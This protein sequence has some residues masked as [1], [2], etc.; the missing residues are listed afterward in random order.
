M[1]K[2]RL[3]P[4][5]LRALVPAKFF[6][7][8]AL[9]AGIG[10][11][12]C[13]KE[14]NVGLALQ[15]QT[16]LLNSRVTDTTTLSTWVTKEKPLP[17]S[18]GLYQFVLGHYW[19]PIFGKTKASI[20]TQFVLP[21]SIINTDFAQG[22]DE[23]KLV[24]DSLVVTLGYGKTFYGD[25][26][27]LQTVKVYQLANPITSGV[28]YHSDTTIAV[29]PTPVGVRSFYPNPHRKIKVGRD[30][31]GPHIRVALDPSIGQQ[32][33]DQSG[34]SPLAS[35]TN[36]LAWM[37]GFY[38]VS[39]SQLGNPGT[40]CML[41]LPLTDPLSHLTLYY[42]NYNTALHPDTSFSFDVNS[43][44][45]RYAHFDHDYRG[46]DPVV[47]NDTMLASH[48]VQPV[49]PTWLP[50]MSPPSQP[51]LFVSALAGLK[52]KIE[53]PYIYNWRK[54]GL[55]SINKAELTVKVIPDPPATNPSY[56]PV[57]KL[58]LVNIDSLGQEVI[59]M[60]NLEG[61]DYFGGNFDAI[62]NQ[63]VFHI[64]RYMQQLI[65]GKQRNNGL[66]LVAT[67]SANN[68]NRVVL[69]GAANTSGFKMT[70]RLSYTRVH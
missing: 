14:S 49:Y 35:T 22:Q 17:T 39:E 29:N 33:L 42:K 36:F 65:N 66:Y 48:A 54:G 68:A 10:G 60:D 15:P 13:K 26:N 34:K 24:C 55:I 52:T 38:I 57:Q 18:G 47:R 32:I 59:L 3:I 37:K 51:I 58:A 70:M 21:N 63:Y 46:A 19:D 64:D 28:I 50:A 11:T 8:A 9:F 1:R 23:T 27:V 30:T 43:V 12:S 5:N 44:A 25:T 41:Y 6:L 4:K 67:G 45:M 7:C 69:G 61:A 2:R 20:Y 16:D 53:F 56:A 62:N 40:G 31:L